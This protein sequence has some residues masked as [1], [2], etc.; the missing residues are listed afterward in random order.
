VH[1]TFQLIGGKIIRNNHTTQVT[2]FVV[3]LAGKCV[4]GIKMNWVSYLINEL[5]KEFRKDQDKGYEFHISW[6][7]MLVSFVAWKIHKGSTFSEREPSESLA[8][9]LST[10]W[11]TNDMSKKC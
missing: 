6:L 3:D 9:R 5:E 8:A 11:Y 4:E 2:G 1:L 7:L 10:F